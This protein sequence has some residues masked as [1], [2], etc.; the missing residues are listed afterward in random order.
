[1]T[2]CKDSP[3]GVRDVFSN[4]LIDPINGLSKKKRVEK[5]DDV[6]PDIPENILSAFVGLEPTPLK[7]KFPDQ[8]QATD[9]M[10]KIYFFD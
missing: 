9:H 3:E 5:V 6:L 10:S 2:L 1:M 8:I 4:R 7:R